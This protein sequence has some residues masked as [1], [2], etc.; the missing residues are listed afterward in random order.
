[1]S[2]SPKSRAT[3]TNTM[4]TGALLAF[5]YQTFA[6]D[7]TANMEEEDYVNTFFEFRRA[8]FL[9]GRQRAKSRV[10]KK[11]YPPGS[12]AFL[13]RKKV[14]QRGLSLASGSQDHSSLLRT[15]TYLPTRFV[16][17]R[18]RPPFR[19]KEAGTGLSARSPARN[20]SC[21]LRFGI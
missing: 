14:A 2:A 18:S 5:I 16:L 11:K 3:H 1:M 12:R 7:R 17:A 19:A 4:G 20:G 13:V 8:F 10:S 15:Y 21:F 9:T 6:D